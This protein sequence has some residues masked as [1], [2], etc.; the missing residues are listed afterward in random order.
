MIYYNCVGY[1][2]ISASGTSYLNRAEANMC[3]QVVTYML[4]SGVNPQQIGVITPYEGQRFYV[5]NLMRRSGSLRAELYD[6]IEVASVDSFQGR[7]KDFII[8]SCVRSN[9]HQGIGFLNDPRRLNVAL[10]RAR[11]GLV[12][13]GNPKVLSKQPLWNNLLCHFKENNC[14]VE[15]PLNNLKLSMVQFQK[16]RKFIMGLHPRFHIPAV[17]ETLGGTLMPGMPPNHYFPEG[18]YPEY[19]MGMGG[20]MMA[21]YG[22]I[23]PPY[24]PR[25]PQP[26]QH[27]NK[28]KRGG[29]K[30]QDCRNPQSQYSQ[31]PF[32][33]QSLGGS[34]Y[35][36][37]YALSQDS[38]YGS[39]YSQGPSN[40][41]TQDS[42][43]DGFSST[44]GSESS[45]KTQQF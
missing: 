39:E 21:P 19:G 37:R 8:L 18:V 23:Q 20:G 43:L 26:R 41:G 3:E 5:V 36:D 6:E 11:Y 27:D 40:L 29:K 13:L 32:T 24:D 34:Q 30:Q 22:S 15:G 25:G 16:P 1:E 44:Q 45:Y 31:S 35:S 12:I 7:E 42:F 38:N 10:T 9:D 28:S 4:K 33:Q 14:L 17:I 2:E